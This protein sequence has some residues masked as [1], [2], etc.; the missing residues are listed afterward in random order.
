MPSDNFHKSIKWF[1]IILLIIG[2]L[3]KTQYFNHGV[4]IS[5]IYLMLRTPLRYSK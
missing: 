2:V 3:W 5:L 4:A 1:I